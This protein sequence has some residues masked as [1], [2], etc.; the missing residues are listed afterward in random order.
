MRTAMMA[1]GR[2]PRLLLPELGRPTPSKLQPFGSQ[3]KHLRQQ[4]V[5]PSCRRQFSAGRSADDF[6][7]APDTYLERG[8]CIDERDVW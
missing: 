1:L 6:Y 8:V 5:Y 2:L 4:L 7:D 3:L